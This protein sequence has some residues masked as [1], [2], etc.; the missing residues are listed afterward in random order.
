MVKYVLFQNGKK[1]HD[2]H[3]ITYSVH[4]DRGTGQMLKIGSRRQSITTRTGVNSSSDLGLKNT[5]I[6]HAIPAV[7]IQYI[8]FKMILYEIVT[9]NF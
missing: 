5:T 9:I 7:F 4:V 3:R 2:V 1:S 8:Y 6:N